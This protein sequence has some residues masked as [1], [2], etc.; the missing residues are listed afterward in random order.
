MIKDEIEREN[1]ELDNQNGFSTLM[2]GLDCLRNMA[3]SIKY[4][5]Y[6]QYN[7]EDIINENFTF[8]LLERKF[9]FKNLNIWRLKNNLTFAYYK[10]IFK[11][12]CKV[13]L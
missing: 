7:I 11:R 4:I 5:N 2:L 8:K 3:D 1:F 10:F 12:D 6:S 13:T 9:D